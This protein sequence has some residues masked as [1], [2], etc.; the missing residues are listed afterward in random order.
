M[1]KYSLKSSGKRPGW[2]P[3]SLKGKLQ[4]NIHFTY[5]LQRDRSESEIGSFKKRQIAA[6][7]Q[8]KPEEELYRAC[9]KTLG[10]E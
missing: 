4:R 1:V 2:I 7:D 9:V 10:T 6:T 5:G 3:K 8:R